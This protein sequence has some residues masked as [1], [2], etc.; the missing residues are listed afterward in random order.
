MNLNGMFFADNNI[1]SEEHGE[2]LSTNGRDCSTFYSHGRKSEPAKDKDWVQDD[3]GDGTSQLEQHWIDHVSGC[4]KGFLQSNFNKA[5][6]GEDGYNG[7]IIN[8]HL[9]NGW[10]ICEGLEKDAAEE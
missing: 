8:T 9:N 1:D 10:V 6:K 2:N 7:G 5:S 4:L 3:I